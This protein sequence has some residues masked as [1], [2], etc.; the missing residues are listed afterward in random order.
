[1]IEYIIIMNNHHIKITNHA[2]NKQNKNIGYTAI[3]FLSYFYPKL[4]FI[5][6]YDP[7]ITIIIPIVDQT[8]A[9][10]AIINFNMK[11]SIPICFSINTVIA[12][13]TI[14]KTQ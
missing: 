9:T 1:M 2:M 4:T 12:A 6:E 11:N 5:K 10:P 13:K 8:K 7:N 3:K 14:G